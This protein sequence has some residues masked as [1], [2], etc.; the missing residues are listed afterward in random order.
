MSCRRSARVATEQL[1]HQR[2][3]LCVLAEKQTHPLLLWHI[4]ARAVFQHY[5]LSRQGVGLRSKLAAEALK[6]VC[7]SRLP[8][9]PLPTNMPCSLWVTLLLA[10]L[11]PLLE[12]PLFPSGNLREV[13]GHSGSSSAGLPMTLHPG[14]WVIGLQGLNTSLSR[15]PQW[16][17]SPL[18]V[19]GVCDTPRPHRKY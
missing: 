6:D 13:K 4:S 17:H 9:L 12:D 5:R 19:T 15:P 10:Q 11:H 18:P 7:S 16:A 8:P 3:I 14:P 2:R 1:S